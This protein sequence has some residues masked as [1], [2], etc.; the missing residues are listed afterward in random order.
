MARR[1]E[2]ARLIRISPFA[3]HIFARQSASVVEKNQWMTRQL[4]G[5]KDV[6]NLT[7]TVGH[8]SAKDIFDTNAYSNDPRSQFMNWALVANGAWDYPA[9]TLGFTNGAAAELNT[10]AWTGRLGVF[11]VSKVANG[12]RLDWN[13]A[14]AWSAVA[15]IERRYSPRGHAGSFTPARV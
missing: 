4:G 3:A 15:E 14:H 5:T 1:I 2:S 8:L 13:L 6:R 7:L 12:I 10:R 9:N 11:Q